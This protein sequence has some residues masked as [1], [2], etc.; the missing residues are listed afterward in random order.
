M[1]LVRRL[2]ARVTIALVCVLA[3]AGLAAPVVAQGGAAQG[4]DRILTVGVL[5]TGCD[6]VGAS[7]PCWDVAT[8]VAAP[9]DQVTLRADLR[10]SDNLHNLHVTKGIEAAPKTDLAP[11]A[12]H[13]VKFTMPA[14]GSVTFVCDVHPTMTS[15]IVTPA[16]AAASGG[17]HETDVVHMGVNFLAYWVGLIAFALLFIVYG[18]TFF[19]FKYNETPSTTDQW[20]RAGEGGPGGERRFSAGAASLLALVFAAVV[21]GAVVY[22]ARAG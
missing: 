16:V 12:L 10:N 7:D 3:L 8:L 13:E 2:P 9:G 11:K 18:L 17:G 22:L 14:S 20:D 21:I 5:E 19:L 1:T 4:I 6:A 15:T